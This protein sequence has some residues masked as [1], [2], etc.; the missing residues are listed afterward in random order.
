MSLRVLI[1]Y[2]KLKL[3]G[4]HGPTLND[5]VPIADTHPIAIRFPPANCMISETCL[6]TD[7]SIWWSPTHS[8]AAPS[9]RNISMPIWA[10]WRT[11]VVT[12]LAKLSIWRCDWSWKTAC[13]IGRPP[14]IYGETIG[15]SFPG[16]PSKTGLKQ[17]EK[18]AEQ[19]I[20]TD[21]LDG[22]LADFSGYI[23]ADELYDGPFC[24]LSMV[25]NRNFNRLI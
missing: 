23:A 19:R 3:W 2:P 4:V 9:T 20:T 24:V 25:D 18:K 7:R 10:T 11:P 15:F 8:I 6:P 14:G 16:L 5:R 22:A 21:Y 12:I 13:P 17:R 1:I